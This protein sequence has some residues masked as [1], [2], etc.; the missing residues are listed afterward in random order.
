MLQMKK[1]NKEFMAAIKMADDDDRKAA[2]LRRETRSSPAEGD[3]D[4]MIEYLLSTVAE[5][6]EYEISRNR[7]RLDA[8]FFR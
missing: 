4:G 1:E 3:H 6:M 2:L 7:P 5:D 8:G